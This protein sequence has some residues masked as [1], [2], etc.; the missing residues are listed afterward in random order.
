MKSL[1]D[2]KHGE[3]FDSPMFCMHTFKWYLRILPHGRS[4]SRTNISCELNLVSLP[5]KLGY[6]S[7]KIKQYLSELNIFHLFN[8]M[9]VDCRTNHTSFKWNLAPSAISIQDS[10]SLNIGVYI[11]LL[12]VY[13]PYGELLTSNY[14]SPKSLVTNKSDS[15]KPAT[16]TY[17]LEIFEHPNADPFHEKLCIGFM[18][19]VSV[20]FD[21]KIN[22][23]IIDLCAVY[24]SNNWCT[25]H[26]MKQAKSGT[27]FDSRTFPAHKFSWFVRLYPAGTFSSGTWSWGAS[28]G[29]IGYL[30]ITAVATNVA[31]VIAH[32]KLYFIE[33]NI[34]ISKYFTF[35]PKQQFLEF[36]T[37]LKQTDIQHLKSMTI[38]VEIAL[39][40]VYDDR[41]NNLT[42]KYVTPY[43]VYNNLWMKDVKLQLQSHLEARYECEY[44]NDVYDG[45]DKDN[46][47][48]FVG[49]KTCSLFPDL[50]IKVADTKNSGWNWT[51][52]SF[53]S[54]IDIELHSKVDSIMCTMKELT[55]KIQKIEELMMKTTDVTKEENDVKLTVSP[56]GV[57]NDNVK[58]WLEK[59][60]KLGQYVNLFCLNG[61]DT[62]DII[63]LITMDTLNQIGIKKVGH[64]LKILHH[65]KQLKQ[66]IDN[67]L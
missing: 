66:N 36:D 10:K 33:L 60:V 3:Y 61:F 23:D 41:G 29:F 20:I 7:I 62:L 37:G 53:G 40:D 52:N 43:L 1:Q 6:V 38:N 42:S 64:K 30:Y 44:I 56:D 24:C 34:Q 47:I 32:C 55:M 25:V 5:P 17:T 65:V 26:M 18:R 28:G 27:N 21:D 8:E 45:G 58:Q 57:I 14:I 19:N 59:E 22:H 49:D 50:E 9:T 11:T 2:A 54:N 46:I 67:D 51:W 13:D 12:D 4:S 15:H 48:E 31:S 63:K 39:L 16:D 35:S